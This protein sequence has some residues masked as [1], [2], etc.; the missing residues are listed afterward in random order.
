LLCKAVNLFLLH[1]KL[2]ATCHCIDPRMV[3]TN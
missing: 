2:I 3:L 1:P